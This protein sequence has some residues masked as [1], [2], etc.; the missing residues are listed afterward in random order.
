VARFYARQLRDK[1]PE[2]YHEFPVRTKQGDIAWLGQHAQLVFHGEQVAG[3]QAIARDITDRKK[4]EEAL[5]QSEEKYRSIIE[6]IEEGYYEVD[7]AG[8]MLFFNDS[9]CAI[10]GYTRGELSGMNSR[11]FMDEPNAKNIYD[12]FNMIYRTGKPSGMFSWELLTKDGS[13]RSIEASASLV[14]DVHGKPC[15]FRGIC[16]DVTERKRAEQLLLRSERLNAVGEL[17]TGV[18]H[19]FNNLLQIITGLGDIISVYIAQGKPAAAEEHVQHILNAC[20]MGAETVKRLQNF[21]RI[22]SSAAPCE[23]AIFDLSHTIQQALDVTEI[24]WKTVPEKQGITI[25]VESCLDPGCWVDGRENEL[26]E[27]AVNLIKNA[28]EALPEGG[29]ISVQARVDHDDVI[30][31]LTDT[32]TGIC[33]EHVGRIFEPFF[34]TKGFQSSGM[35]LAS[36]YGIVSQHNGEVGVE[37]RP[38][39]GTSFTVRLPFVRHQPH[40]EIPSCPAITDVK[41]RILVID[42]IEDVVTMLSE[43]LTELGQCVLTARSGREALSV[44]SENSVDLVICDLGMPGMN[45]WDVAAAIKG[46][47]QERQVPKPPLVLLT[48]W[49]GQQ[50]E[51]ETIFRSGVDAVVEKPVNITH[52]IEIIRHLLQQPAVA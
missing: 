42:D 4:S 14:R 44:F 38:G 15:G 24:W 41:A 49:G 35:G 8:N 51:A 20:R 33:Q 12:T 5:R 18:A 22:R 31:R 27:V 3:F 50:A 6:E 13:A 28:V 10:L 32:G 25:A 36:T 19:N 26:F 7:L 23:R 17:A 40:K 43:G 9:L 16:R 1:I 47:C 52:L 39:M 2:T 21:A 48:G 29:N 45:G 37:T 30:L 34:T 46:L 11:Q